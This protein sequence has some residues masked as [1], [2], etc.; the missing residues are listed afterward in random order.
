MPKIWIDCIFNIWQLAKNNE[1]LPKSLHIFAK[2]QLNLQSFASGEIS[3]NPVTLI[4]RDLNVVTLFKLENE[5]L[6]KQGRFHNFW[7]NKYRK[8]NN[9]KH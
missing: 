5:T 1:S 9:L 3:A 2:Y 4:A 6:F 7:K 8:I